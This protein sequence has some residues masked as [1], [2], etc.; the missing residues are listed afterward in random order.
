[1]TT[2]ATADTPST[3]ARAN[4][5]FKFAVFISYS[6]KDRVWVREQLIPRLERANLRYCYD[7]QM[8]IGD[9]FQLWMEGQVA[10]C[11]RVLLV[12]TRSWLESQWSSHEQLLA[13]RADPLNRARRIIPVLAEAGCDPPQR[14]GGYLY[15]DLTDPAGSEAQWEKLI[16]SL[17]EEDTAPP[18]GGGGEPERFMASTSVRRGLEDLKDLLGLDE[19]KAMVENYRASFRSASTQMALIG[20]YKALHDKFHDVQEMQQTVA[21]S[22][23]SGPEDYARWETLFGEVPVLVQFLDDAVEAARGASFN[24]GKLS[25]IRRMQEAAGQL[26]EALNGG[27]AQ[28][29]FKSLSTVRREVNVQLTALNGGLVGAAR[30]LYLAALLSNLERIRHRLDDYAFVGRAAEQRD[31]FGVAVRSLVELGCL[32]TAMIENHAVLQTVKDRVD[33][34]GNG[35][36]PTLDL[37][38][39]LDEWPAIPD[40]LKE[41]G[42]IREGQ[43]PLCELS[44]WF[45]KL[46]ESAAK[47]T[48]AA[49]IDRNPARARGLLLGFESLVF[50]CFYKTDR[51]LL[52]LCGEMQSIGRGLDDLLEAMRR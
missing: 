26:D 43:R 28:A 52:K 12:V 13:A 19:V 40:D 35:H 11:R 8:K 7:D 49:E 27:D 21:T 38:Q 24:A 3:P 37:D 4:G 25:W 39:F 10:L 44:R 6:H 16:A 32:W 23:P 34:L 46:N 45:D 22:R 9:D 14:I 36:G 20:E 17:R 41:L 31:G 50:Q 5:D 2:L 48:T 47:V 15:A 33:A 29:L 18:A 42:G 30:G 51:E 1:M